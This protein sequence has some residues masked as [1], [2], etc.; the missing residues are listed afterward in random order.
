M[1][2]ADDFPE[3]DPLALLLARA[4]SAATDEAARDALL[5]GL[6]KRPDLAKQLARLLGRYLDERGADEDDKQ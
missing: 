6:D 4:R 2:E 1:S 5:E 3:D